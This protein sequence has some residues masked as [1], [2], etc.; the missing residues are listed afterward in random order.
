MKADLV[1]FNPTTVIDRSTFSDPQKPSEG[2]EKVFV[3]G[4]LVWD[5]GKAIGA[6]PG[7]VLSR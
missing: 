4:E 6:R 3:N 2:I 5:A 7:S 1:L